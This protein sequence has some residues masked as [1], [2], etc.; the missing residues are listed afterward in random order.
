MLNNILSWTVSLAV[1]FVGFCLLIGM[2]A[3][4]AI[5]LLICLIIVIFCTLFYG[6]YYVCKIG[7]CK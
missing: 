3:V 7:A 4:A 6:I 1:Q 5:L 2:V